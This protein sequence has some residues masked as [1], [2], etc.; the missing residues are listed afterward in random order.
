[1]QGSKNFCSDTSDQTVEIP[2]DPFVI[3]DP[4][5]CT[6]PASVFSYQIAQDPNI[7]TTQIKV[8]ADPV[9]NVI[10]IQYVSVTIDMSLG[11]VFFPDFFLKGILPNGQVFTTQFGIAFTTC[12]GQVLTAPA[13][14]PVDQLY[15][16]TDPA[17]SQ[18]VGE[19]TSNFPNCA[20]N[21]NN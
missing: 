1:M 7:D 11:D 6:D 9:Q 8:S 17:G 13:I 3:T 12:A 14:L 16:V 2:F 4:S 20:I 19:F 15:Y 21:Y 18:T 10:R 5:T